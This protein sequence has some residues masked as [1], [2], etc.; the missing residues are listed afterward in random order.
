MKARIIRCTVSEGAIA[1]L[2]GQSSRIHRLTIPEADDLVITPHRGSM[3]V[4]SGQGEPEGE[5][6]VEID[7]SSDLVR[8]A[9]AFLSTKK[10]LEG[11]L[12]GEAFDGHFISQLPD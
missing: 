9:E 6:V 10:T 5:V 8:E 2:H 11:L 4:W 7:V 12:G 3:H 1:A